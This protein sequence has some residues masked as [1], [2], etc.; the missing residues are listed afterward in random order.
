MPATKRRRPCAI[1]AAPIP[2][3]DRDVCTSCAQTVPLDLEAAR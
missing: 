1:C 3:D 2:R